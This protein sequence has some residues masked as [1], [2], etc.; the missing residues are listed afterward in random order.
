MDVDAFDAAT[1]LPGIEEGAVDQILDRELQVCV[2]RDIGGVLAPEFE[3]ERRER[4]RRG[5]LHRAARLDRPCEGDMIDKAARD[6]G[7]RLAVL[8]HDMAEQALREADGVEGFLEPVADQ[9]RLR[10]LL[11]QHGV[12]GDQRRHDRVDGRQIGV[13]PRRDGEHDADRFTGDV[14]FVPGPRVDRDRGRERRRRDFGHIAHALVDALQLALPVADRPP[15][16]PGQ[17]LRDLGAHV[18]ERVRH[19]HDERRAFLDGN[20]A[21]RLLGCARAR[22]RL[23]DL[24]LAG[25]RSVDVNP[26]VDRRDALDMRH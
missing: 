25:G 9:Q 5:A 4:A 17:F 1:A 2:G 15:H 12:A 14:A 6:D 19:A 22:E 18:L 16:L 20:M 10:G 3:P 11:K 23:A 7:F 24:R 13:V 26:A 21:P 8:E